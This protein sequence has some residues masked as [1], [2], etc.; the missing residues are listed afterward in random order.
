MFVPSQIEKLVFFDIETAGQQ[1]DLNELPTRLQDLWAKRA[2][3][4]RTGLSEKYPENADKDP[5]ELFRM[6]AALQAEFGRVVCITFGKVKFN[7]EGDPV[8]QL[9]TYKDSDEDVLLRQA[10]N[11]IDKMS[12]QG[13][14][15]C[16]HN[17]KRFD[18]PFLCKRGI[19][20]SIPL[21]VPLQLF[22]KKPWEMPFV[23]TSEV[24]SF[25]AWQEGFTSLDLL[26]CVLGIDSPKE[27]IQGDQVHERYYMGEIDRIAS[28]CERDVTALAQII[29]R[30]S[31]QNLIDP[32][33]IIVK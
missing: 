29:L 3:Y 4:L 9:I 8:F 15:M 33:N 13:I 23:D 10:F 31:G 14:K 17:I 5:S 27:D 28:Y 19:I 1:A 18:I 32:V 25:G 2:E 11:L 21:P 12:K 26:T 30:I 20:N 24:W 16:G 6:K 7:E 22:D